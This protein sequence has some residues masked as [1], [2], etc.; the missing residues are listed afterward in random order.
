MSTAP[1]DIS[2]ILMSSR[3]SFIYLERGYLELDGN[4]VVFRQGA[5]TLIHV[6]VGLFTCILLGPG[7]VV[8]H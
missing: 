7:T 2:K 1:F 4:A 3:Y 8:T 6:P 5:N